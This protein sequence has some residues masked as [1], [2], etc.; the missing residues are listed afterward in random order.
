MGLLCIGLA[1]GGFFLPQLSQFS[2]KMLEF[3]GTWSWDQ[4]FGHQIQ[5]RMASFLDQRHG[6]NAPMA[7]KMGVQ[8]IHLLTQTPLVKFRMKGIL[9]K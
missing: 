9:T 7:L 3:V 1:F 2:E 5:L 6:K 8:C 4:I